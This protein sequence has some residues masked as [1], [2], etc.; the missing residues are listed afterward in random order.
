M[1]GRA[2]TPHR[3]RSRERPDG[4]HRRRV[5][6]HLAPVRLE[7]R[8]AA[9]GRALQ[10]VDRAVDLVHPVGIEPGAQELAVDVGR[11]DERPERP[12]PGPP[13]QD[14]EPRM[15]LR[16]AIEVQAVAV[17]PP[18]KVGVVAEPA[19]VGQGGETQAESGVGGIGA[20]EPFAAP[21]VGQA[22]VDP[23]AGPLRR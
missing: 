23:H 15:G 3:R 11:V 20:P 16:L 2:S 1:F 13:A 6:L 18:G 9:P 19:G 22:A 4:P 8:D 7:D 10:V 5:D 17:E 14:A 12:P 21:E